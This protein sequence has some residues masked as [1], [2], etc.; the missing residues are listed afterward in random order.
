MEHSTPTHDPLEL[1]HR[2]LCPVTDWLVL[3]GD[4]HHL[5]HHAEAQVAS[6]IADGITTVIDLREEWSD[7]E[8]DHF[9]RSTGA[10]PGTRER[11]LAALEEWMGANGIDLTSLVRRIRAEVA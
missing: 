10:S 1:W 7:E 11:D 3:S 4:L 2:R 5:R 9:H 6:W 8:L